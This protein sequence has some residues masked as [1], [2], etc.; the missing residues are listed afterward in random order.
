MGPCRD[1]CTVEEGKWARTPSENESEM[2]WS[3]GD[4]KTFLVVNEYIILYLTAVSL[5]FSVPSLEPFD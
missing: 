2:F 5:V 1:L 3:G 4:E